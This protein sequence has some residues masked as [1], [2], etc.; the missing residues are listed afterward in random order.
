MTEYG[1]ITAIDSSHLLI[2]AV[3]VEDTDTYQIP[4]C[5][6]IRVIGIHPFEA[7]RVG[8][9]QDTQQSSEPIDGFSLRVPQNLREVEQE[10]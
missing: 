6:Q 5:Y 3:A 10:L 2:V 7:V 9:F 8:S 4:K 1:T